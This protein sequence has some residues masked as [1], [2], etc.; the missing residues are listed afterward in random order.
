MPNLGGDHDESYQELADRTPLAQILTPNLTPEKMALLLK[1]KAPSGHEWAT[2]EIAGKLHAL[3][4]PGM[5]QYRIVVNEFFHA[6]RYSNETRQQIK[7][8]VARTGMAQNGTISS[9]A[10]R[11]STYAVK[12]PPP[13]VYQHPDVMTRCGVTVLAGRPK[14][15]KSYL[16]LNLALSVSMGG[17]FVSNFQMD[18]P[19]DVLYLALE[20]NASRMWGRVQALLGGEG[21]PPD[22]VWLAYSAPT[23][24]E[25][26]LVQEIEDWINLPEVVAPRLIVIDI[27]RLVQSHRGRKDD[28][29]EIEYNDMN[30]LTRLAQEHDLHILIVTHLNKS[31]SNVEDMSDAIM[32]STAIS[33]GASGIWVMA[34]RGEE[35]CDA[36]LHI[37]GK[38]VPRWSCGLQQVKLEGHMDWK[39]LGDV[40][41]VIQGDVKIEILTVLY[42]W[43]G[44]NPIQTELRDALSSKID[45]GNFS[46]LLKKMRTDGLIRVERSRYGLTQAGASSAQIFNNLDNDDNS[47]NSYNSDNNIEEVIN[48]QIDNN[49]PWEDEIDESF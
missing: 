14:M 5:G 16:A 13:Q 12:P 6:S 10:D 7:Q 37:S 15:G 43:E 22:N 25:G 39:A 8:M 11:L 17:L 33:G 4:Q 45:R 18:H 19:G 20:D 42:Q 35:R 46:R 30:Q 31:Y 49:N 41:S 1:L 28:L 21:K 40:E 48:N 47:Y 34:G 26:V 24:D 29:Y 23:L 36:E 44:R 38:D 32:S 27:F 3:A 9:K 2:D